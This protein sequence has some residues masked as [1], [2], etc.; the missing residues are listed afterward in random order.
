M[1]VIFT[2]KVDIVEWGKLLDKY[3]KEIK[4]NHRKYY[5]P[6]AFLNWCIEKGYAKEVK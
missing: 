1:D 4:Y 5:S 3:K 2:P 6:K